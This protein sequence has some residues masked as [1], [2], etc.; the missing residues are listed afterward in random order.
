M[1]FLYPDPVPSILE[2]PD[3][4]R[5][6]EPE[7]FQV[8]GAAAGEG[9]RQ[10]SLM[11][12]ADI[13][14]TSDLF[15]DELVAMDEEEWERSPHF[16]PGIKW[17]PGM[18]EDNAA[19][20]A[21]RADIRAE[22]QFIIS[23]GGTGTT[24]AGFLAGGLLDPVNLIPFTAGMRGA[25][26][27]T[28]IGRGAVENALIEA[29][30]QPLLA[31]QASGFQEDYDARMALTN[32]LGAAA[33]GGG[34][35]GVGNALRRVSPA[36][37]ALATQKATVDMASGRPIDV[38]NVIPERIEGVDAVDT[39]PLIARDPILPEPESTAQPGRLEPPDEAE[40]QILDQQVAALEAEGRLT[41]EDVE[42]LKAVDEEAAKDLKRADA[43]EA[44]AICLTS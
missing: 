23:R 32:I 42:S 3:V 35:A 25:K 22:R 7:T 44:A 14:L 15:D 29:A 41:A 18:T 17:F 8:L 10:T 11:A 31:A 19:L 20:L 36:L 2:Q 21:E 16:R 43:F 9:F 27:L 39:T 6:F 1:A 28:A 30:L 33:L 13:F 4:S 38:S 24:L 26:L 37:R 34:F 40:I 12:L 5:T